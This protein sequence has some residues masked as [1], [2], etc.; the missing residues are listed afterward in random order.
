MVN[1]ESHMTS[2]SK[3]VIWVWFLLHNNLRFVQS[4]SAVVRV[5]YFTLFKFI[6]GAL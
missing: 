2:C 6:V 1:L 3:A 4:A 5:I